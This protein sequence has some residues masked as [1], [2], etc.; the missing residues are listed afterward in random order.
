MF[1]HVLAI[2]AAVLVIASSVVRSQSPP[3]AASPQLETFLTQLQ[4][5]SESGN[6][7]AVAAM[8]RY[9]ITIA[10]SGLRVPFGD[11]ASVVARYDDIFNPALRDV[12]ARASVR[13]EGGKQQV[14]VGGDSYVVGTGDIVI[15]PFEG[16]LLI[17]SIAVPLF[18]GSGSVATP[19][20]ET[21]A[22]R[23]EPRRIAIRVGARPTQIPGLLA[24]ATTDSYLL[25]LPKG[26]LAG[27]RLERVPAGA[28]VI[29][30][31]HARTG[32]P[33]SARLSADG[34]FVTGRPPEGADYR[35]EVRRTDNADEAAL[36]YMLSLTLR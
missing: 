3:A 2:A 28:A 15:T 7:E 23:L 26:Q 32:A 16:R 12:I 8:I 21:S 13:A 29:R 27:V 5:A 14:T 36:P 20:V 6:R 34:R 11:A 10:I 35:I 1:R 24:R 31:V 30:V 17:S 19:P 25:Y 22:V 4:T 9:P 33:L 18:D